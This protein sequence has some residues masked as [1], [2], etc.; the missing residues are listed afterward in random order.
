MRRML[1]Y[2]K[3]GPRECRLCQSQLSEISGKLLSLNG[4]IPSDF[5]R[6]PRSLDELERWKATEF[7]QFLLYTGVIALKGILPPAQF[8]HFLTL[9]I[10]TRIMLDTNSDRRSTHLDYAKQVMKYFVAKSPEFYDSK[11]ECENFNFTTSSE[12]SGDEEDLPRKRKIKQREFPECF[13]T[14]VI[15]H[16]AA[17]MHSSKNQ[18]SDF[19]GSLNCGQS[20]GF[21]IVSC[22]G[23]KVSPF[24]PSVN[25]LNHDACS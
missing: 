10:T 18:A 7:R 25:I 19:Y 21:E 5:V 8:E 6:Q 13:P 11:E 22:T 17:T 3:K 4:K 14:S 2:L 15:K 16:L 23:K 24:K 20:S 9:S 12:L 1:T